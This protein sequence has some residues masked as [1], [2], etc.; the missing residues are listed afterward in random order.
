DAFLET[1]WCRI[2]PKFL[3]N[4]LKAALDAVN[5]AHVFYQ[6]RLVDSH[7]LRDCGTELEA[8]KIVGRV[9]KLYVN[10]HDNINFATYRDIALLVSGAQQKR[11][12]IQIVRQTQLVYLR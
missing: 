8:L 9:K 12:A 1:D 10:E 5:V 7:Q 3:A 4:C 6:G 2:T 11:R